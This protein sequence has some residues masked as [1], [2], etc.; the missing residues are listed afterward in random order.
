MMDRISRQAL[1]HGGN[2]NAF[3][4]LSQ[5]AGLGDGFTLLQRCTEINAAQ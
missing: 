5:H 4:T 3:V 1:G 2:D